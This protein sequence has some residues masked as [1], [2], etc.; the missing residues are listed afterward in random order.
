MRWAYTNSGSGNVGEFISVWKTDNAGTSTSTQISLPLIT[1][2]T[3]DMTV[4]WGDST[5]SD[6]TSAS[7]ADKTHTYIVA[8]TYTVTIT[9]TNGGIKFDNG[10]DK[11]KLITI[12][13]WGSLNISADSC[14]YGCSN[15]N[16][17]ARDAPLITAA[18]FADMF[19][20]CSSLAGGL[21][22]FDVSG[23]QTFKECFRGCTVFNGDVSLWDTSSA[24]T[25]DSCFYSCTAFNGDLSAWDVS[26]VTS[27]NSTFYNCTAFNG[28][29]S[30]WDVSSVTRFTGAFNEC[31]V[32][33]QD[34]SSWDVTAGQYGGGS[35]FYNCAAFDQDLSGWDVTA[36]TDFTSMFFGCKLSTA[37]YDALLIAWAALD[38]VN[39]KS[40]HGGTSMY[41]SGAAATARQSL[42]DDDLWTITD[43]GLN[44]T[45][46]VFTGV[47][48]VTLPFLLDGVYDV[49]VDWGDS[50]TSTI[51][52]YP[53]SN[54][55][56]WL[57][58]N[59]HT[60]SEAGDY[61][62][63]M[64]GVVEGWSF[65][66]WS[67]SKNSITN[68]QNWGPLN[69]T[70]NSAFYDCA[71]LDVS[72]PDQPTVSTTD[73]S[74]TFYN[75]SS[76]TGVG[77]AWGTSLVTNFQAIFQNCSVFNGDLSAW[78]VSSGTDFR[79]AF[80]ACSVFNGDLSEWDVSSMQMAQ[81]M[82]SQCSAF[83]SDLS[84]WNVS[85]LQNSFAMFDRATSFNS[86]ISGWTLTSIRYMSNMFFGA[87]SFNQPIGS[88]AI[89]SLW[90]LPW[91]DGA[92]ALSSFLNGATAFDQDISGLDISGA[93][94]LYNFISGSGMSVANYN[95]TLIGFASQ[96]VK[97]NVTFGSPSATPTGA[98][99]DA[100]NYLIT[101]RSWTFS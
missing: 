71:N 85:S 32:F 68:I 22:N 78:D 41:S 13:Q 7:D 10:G 38:V 37:N 1:G 27:L 77:G 21:Q 3:Y 48:S 60:Y 9:G 88:W 64:T 58:A 33:N 12:T 16:I 56:T 6:I 86:D 75:C 51:E 90:S 42:I 72:A 15:L 73:L 87:T 34:I 44:E 39:S 99:L 69:I 96:S 63:T 100:K 23:V 49:V 24:V 94:Q 4:D 83:N 5:T 79:Q 14:F 35:M 97:F 31:T 81:Q 52:T 19:R 17:T 74:Y 2:K 50:T 25:L 45:I 82:F 61:T 54:P 11:L 36:W 30:A 40:F 47:T 65:A 8:G 57:A 43:G 28:D 18:G 84:S 26:S 89:S 29:L 20:D 76:L 53:G 95:L 55:G 46:M 80:G 59:T 91:A 98:G 67:A 62:V 66:E 92:F 101:V 70:T 93:T